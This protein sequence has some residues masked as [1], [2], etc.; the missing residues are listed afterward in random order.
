MRNADV[1]T[2]HP[3]SDAAAS[4]GGEDGRNDRP[5]R[6][7]VP[8]AIV[9]WYGGAFVAFANFLLRRSPTR[10]RRTR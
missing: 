3:P 1:E 7:W 5:M 10:R 8:K 4:P 6:R 9:I 2:A